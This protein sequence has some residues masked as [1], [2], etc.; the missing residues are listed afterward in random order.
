[1]REKDRDREEAGEEREQDD[2]KT[3]VNYGP[4]PRFQ[5]VISPS[6]TIGAGTARPAPRAP[7]TGPQ[8]IRRRR[9]GETMA[10]TVASVAAKAG[11]QNRADGVV[12]GEF[13]RAAER[14]RENR[15]P[16]ALYA[17]RWRMLGEPG[18]GNEPDERSDR[19]DQTRSDGNNVMTPA[20]R[21]VTRPAGRA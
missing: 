6:P 19:Q 14:I 3:L 21:F 2:R 4:R 16:E 20:D 10:K 17:C 7:R 15:M 13:P 12:V 5:S 18:R 11:E 9:P 1:M 8:P